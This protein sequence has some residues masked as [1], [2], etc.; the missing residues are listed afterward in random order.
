VISACPWSLV[1][2]HWIDAFDSPNGWINTKEY[3]PQ[4][5]HVVSV[6]WLWADLLEG[7][8]SVTCSYCPNEDP[9]WTQLVWL[10]TSLWAW[11]KKL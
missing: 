11:Y 10:P 7:Y 6:G 5:Q 3:S 9:T 1:A 8:L 2:V 4:T